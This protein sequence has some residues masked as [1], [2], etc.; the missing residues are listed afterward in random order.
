MAKPDKM[1]AVRYTNSV[2]VNDLLSAAVNLMYLF[3]KPT[4]PPGMHTTNGGN[5]VS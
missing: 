1:S 5:C 4:V 3:I 2:S